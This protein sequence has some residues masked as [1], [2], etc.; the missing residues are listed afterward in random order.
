M[1]IM[2]GTLY[3]DSGLH[4][5]VVWLSREVGTVARVW[6]QLKLL[7]WTWGGEGGGGTKYFR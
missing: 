5:G 6:I 7:Y 4:W 2:L 1:L 3:G